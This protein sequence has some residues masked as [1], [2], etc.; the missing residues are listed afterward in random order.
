VL[1]AEN[2][3]RREEALVSAYELM[4]RTHNELGMTEPVEPTSRRYFS[5]PFTVIGADR[6]ADACRA[7]LTDPE[8]AS[9]PLL[10]SVD[11]CV[12]STDV[13]SHPERVARLRSLYR[14]EP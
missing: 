12:D 8:L 9:L 11:Q 3:A 6:F 14:S 1:A 4:A 5:R 2:H 10:G 13:L 7:A